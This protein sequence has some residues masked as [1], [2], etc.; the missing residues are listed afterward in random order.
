MPQPPSLVSFVLS[1]FVAFMSA[2][3]SLGAE[4]AKPG[5][6]KPAVKTSANSATSATATPE[7]GEG[8][9][10]I[11][12]SNKKI[13]L[14]ALYTPLSDYALSYGAAGSYNLSPR[15][16]TGFALLMGTST[17]SQSETE[18][19]VEY[20]A[21]AKITGS[22][23][24]AYGRYFLGNSFN[25]T[26]GLGLRSATINYNAQAGNGA[27]VALNGKVEIQSIVLPLYIGNRWSFDSGFTIGCD[28]IGAMIAVTG[29]AKSSLEGNID[30]QTIKNFNQDFLDLG[31]SLAHKSS[32]TLF[33]TSIGWAF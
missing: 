18:N 5:K 2:A 4:P 20:K 11:A 32:L 14:D 19:G 1:G 23:Y 24:Y 26:G 21:E 27:V 25:V 13:G 16:N 10:Q 8:A 17:V 33:L 22:A 31:N 28:W 7:S 3:A 12:R 9:S 29:S 30:N 6:K 15:I